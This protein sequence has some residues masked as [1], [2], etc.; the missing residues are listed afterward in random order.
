MNFILKVNENFGENI[1]ETIVDPSR[2]GNIGRYIN[3]SCNPNCELIP[4]RVDSLIPKIAI[5]AKKDILEGSELT[6]DYGDGKLGVSKESGAKYR[7]CLCE[8]ENCRKYLPFNK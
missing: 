2:F 3:H 6:F 4:I 1:I 8:E 5:F 7:L